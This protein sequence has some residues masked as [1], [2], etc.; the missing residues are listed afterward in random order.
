MHVNVL[1]ERATINKI[2]IDQMLIVNIILIKPLGLESTL[3][4]ISS[5][6]FRPLTDG[7]VNWQN[8][9]SLYRYNCIS[10]MP[11]SIFTC[12]LVSHSFLAGLSSLLHHLLINSLS[13]LMLLG[14][15]K[16]W[17]RS[18]QDII[19]IKLKFV[20]LKSPPHTHTHTGKKCFVHMVFSFER[21]LS[22][23]PIFSHIP[24]LIAAATAQQKSSQTVHI[25]SPV[26]F[27]F[28]LFKCANK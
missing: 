25:P 26:S 15:E 9:I 24:A 1:N 12:R 16:K 19:V 28:T 7:T 6:I 22:R 4:F 18:A 23:R 17:R 11:Q 10:Q 13:G 20:K 2:W 3:L 8:L 5:Y 14:N 21:H 27:H